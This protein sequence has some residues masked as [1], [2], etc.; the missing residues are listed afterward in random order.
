MNTLVN[1]F[2]DLSNAF[3]TF[4]HKILIKKLEYYGL[5]GLS[6]TLMES[7]LLNRKQYVE[8]DEY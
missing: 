7:Y 6:L 5:H 1:S 8:I 3:D 2:L 4:D